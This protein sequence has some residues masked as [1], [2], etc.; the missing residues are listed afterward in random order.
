MKKKDN[1][2]FCEDLPYEKKQAGSSILLFDYAQVL[3][4]FGVHQHKSLEKFLSKEHF[5]SMLKAKHEG[6]VS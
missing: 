5:C 6:V 4:F 2:D 3:F 1:A